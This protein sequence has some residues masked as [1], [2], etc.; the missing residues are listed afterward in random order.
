MMRF[1]A[2]SLRTTIVNMGRLEGA[3]RIAAT[4]AVGAAGLELH[5]AIKDNISLRDHSLDDLAAMG[6]PYARRHGA[7]QIHRT[8]GGGTLANPENRVHT[9]S[10]ALLG[11]LRHGP[12]GTTTPSYRVWL[13]PAA[14]PHAVHVVYG[15]KVMLPRD[16][17]WD[18]ARGPATQKRMMRSIVRVF[19]K[20]LRTQGGL[21]FAGAARPGSRLGA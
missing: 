6:H 7:I 11:A 15:T 16:V 19:G 9:Q 13:D 4:A 17:L 5:A 21:R 2:G 3:E 1:D 14:A 8:G 18:T 10:G 20:V 12:T